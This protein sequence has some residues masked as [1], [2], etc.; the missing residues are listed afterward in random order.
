MFKR[1]IEHFKR[2]KIYE[3]NSNEWCGGVDSNG[4]RIYDLV[5]I[6]KR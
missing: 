1:I 2:R 5:D 3:Y 6:T 4:D